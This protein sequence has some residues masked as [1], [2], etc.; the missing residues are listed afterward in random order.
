MSSI[1]MVLG[2]SVTEVTEC[3]SGGAGLMQRAVHTFGHTNNCTG[4]FLNA[5]KFSIP[6]G[7][8]SSWVTSGVGKDQSGCWRFTWHSCHSIRAKAAD[9]AQ[10]PQLCLYHS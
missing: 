1:S 2:G 4:L 7:I 8:A 9:L 5:A 3:P 10:N 6:G